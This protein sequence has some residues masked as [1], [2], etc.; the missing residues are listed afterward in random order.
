[1]PGCQV[2]T[3]VWANDEGSSIGQHSPGSQL[4]RTRFYFFP[5]G[6][7][8]CFFLRSDASLRVL[9]LT[10]WRYPYADGCV[11]RGDESGRRRCPG[12]HCKTC[13]PRLPRLPKVVRF[14]ACP[15]PS[16]LS[17]TTQDVMA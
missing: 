17:W 16:W 6:F 13:L 10:A 7:Q 14:C 12:K 4:C 8:W 15:E 9:L 11:N 2:E 1:M 5:V 3:K